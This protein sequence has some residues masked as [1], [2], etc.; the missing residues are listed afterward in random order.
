MGGKV[1]GLIEAAAY[2]RGNFKESASRC[3][4]TGVSTAWGLWGLW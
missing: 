1:A 4:M 3:C 2:G